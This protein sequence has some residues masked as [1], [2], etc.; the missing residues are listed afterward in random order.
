VPE[1]DTVFL[2]ARRLNARLTRQVVTSSDLRV[3]RHATADLSGATLLTTA[4]YGKHLLT[5][6]DT[7]ITLHTHL[8]MDGSWTVLNPG[9]RLPRRLEPDIRVLLGFT[10]GLTAAGLKLPVVELL[11]TAE[12]KE[13]IGHLGP[14]L[15][16]AWD[17]GE[18]AR[19][20]AARPDR[21]A[22]AAL[23]DQTNLA[24]LGNLWVNELLFLRGVHPWR[25]VGSVDL[26]PLLALA[27]KMLRFSVT[28]PGATQVTTGDTRPGH[29]HWV[30]GRAG[31][32]CLRCGTRIEV[33]AETPGDAERRR[34]WWCPHC[35]PAP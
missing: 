22:A 11:R 26:A 13:T 30:A 21:T 3:P 27:A 29:Q 10:S 23:L 18:A 28:T 4:T 15:L 1:G 25:P 2:L 20:L 16:G 12:E 34:T 32:P 33:V 24:G 9:K 5:R 6:F 31:Q 7:G 17:A 14:D 8:R 35:Q 19:R